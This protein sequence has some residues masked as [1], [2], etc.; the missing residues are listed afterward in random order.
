MRRNNYY[1]GGGRYNKRGGY[2]SG[3]YGRRGGYRGY[4]NYQD[5]YY[6]DNYYNKNSKYEEVEVEV[7][8]SN[9][10]IEKEEESIPKNGKEVEITSKSKMAY[11]NDI[12][13]DTYDDTYDG[14][15]NYDEQYDNYGDYD[16]D[17]GDGYDY[18][19][20]YDN[21]DDNYNN[22]SKSNTKNYQN[23]PKYDKMT[24]T[25]E[26]GFTQ[27][28]D[29]MIYY[30]SDE[31]VSDKYVNVLMIAEKP[32]IARAISEVLSGNKFK[33]HKMGRGKCLL[34]FDGS[35]QGAKAR[36]TVSAVAGHVYTSDFLRQHNKWDAI[37]PVELY[38]V[39]IVK[40]E[41]M[42]KMKMPQL[43]QKLAKGKDI[44]CLWL[45]C[46]SEGENICYEVIYNALPYMNKKNYQQIFRAKFSSLTKKDLKEAFNNLSEYADK[47]VSSSVDARQVIDL[48]IGVSFT[49][50]LTSSILPSLI[51][52]NENYKMLSYGP[53]QTPTLWFCVN[54]QNEIKNFVKTP[55]YII[56]I[57]LEICKMRYK[58]SYDKEFQKKKDFEEILKNLKKV[59][60]VKV[61]DIVSEKSSK[62]P[63]AGLNTATLLKIAS[64]FL[65][66]SPHDT[67]VIAENLYTKGYITYPR[68][69]TTKYAPTFDFKGSLNNFSTH[70]DFGENVKKLLKDFQFPIL[71]GVNAGDHPPITPAKVATKNELKGDSWRLYECICNNYFASISPPV[72]YETLIYKFDIDGLNFEESSRV[73]NHEGFLL[74]QPFKKK[75]F[76]KDFPKLEK[77]K[78]YNL[79]TASY[80]ERMTRPPE[81]ITESELIGE[82]EKNHIG[83][84]ASMSVH[85]ENICQRGYV[86]VDEGRHLI[87][88]KLGNALIDALGSVD[89]SIIHPE[90]RA[91]I[92]DFV[93]QVAHGKKVYKDVLKFALELYKE[94]FNIIRVHYNKLLQIFGNYFE[95]D[96]TKIGKEIYNINKKNEDYKKENYHQKK[97]SEVDWLNECD[98]CHKGKMYVDYDKFDKFC[99]FCTNC[100]R[101]TKIIRD[102]LKIEV[103]KDQKCK[104][105]GAIYITVEV[106]NPFLNGETKYTG[107]LFCDKKLS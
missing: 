71:K 20:S 91:K 97:E 35:F 105:C 70:P 62:T 6:D 74:F 24:F 64:S 22:K 8:Q 28:V 3:G 2:N 19:E 86:K 79:I 65:K 33:N 38:D 14:N 76:T 88:S 46:D 60:E 53:C 66:M 68:T 54:R 67:M 83:T 89:P 43:I 81:Y 101:M 107:C 106:E 10:I 57:E 32:S 47:N 69:E 78:P 42:R 55:Y 104:K 13:D 18:N 9:K 48:K 72:E 80:D 92:E 58:I 73:I 63:P 34:T 17:Y 56:Y 93:N 82:M 21:Y 44:L 85:I 12:E 1:R 77:N 16:D 98:E 36:F 27:M 25:D 90:N 4:N 75:G 26:S 84:D 96:R 7:G 15:Y 99:I 40:L 30:N 49:R 103:A 94:K 50:F 5:N 52:L 59:K 29:K 39:P 45:D 87:P 51:G 31:Y 41:A 100:K 37:D 61:S 102:A 95:I 11:K 23:N